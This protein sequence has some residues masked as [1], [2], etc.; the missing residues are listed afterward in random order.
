MSNLITINAIDRDSSGGEFKTFST[1]DVETFRSQLEEWESELIY[2]KYY[3]TTQED[4][5]ECSDEIVE[6]LDEFQVEY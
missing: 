5:D 1:L 6:I 3:L 4:T 2:R